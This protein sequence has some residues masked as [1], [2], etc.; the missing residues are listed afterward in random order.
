M[1]TEPEA[2]TPP[3]ELWPQKTAVVLL[4]LGTPAEPTASAVRPYLRE[5]LFDA[6]VIDLPKL[7]RWLLVNLIIAPFR[8]GTSA[9]KYRRIWTPQGSP[10]MVHS[11]ALRERLAARLADAEVLLAMR[12]GRPSIAEA[13][14]RIDALRATRVVLLPLFPQ[15]SSAAWGS[16]AQAFLRA[17][18]ELNTLPATAVVPP[19]FDHEAFLVASAA[20]LGDALASQPVEHVVFSY[21][22]LPH[23]QAKAAC[24]DGACLVDQPDT[25]CETARPE[26][27]SCYRAQCLATSRQLARRAGVTAFSTVFQSRLGRSAWLG[28][29]LD[30]ALVALARQGLKRVAVACP[31]FVADCLETLEEVG[32]GAKD[33]FLREGGQSFVLVP[34]LNAD[35][36]WVSGL[37][38]LL[39][40]W[41]SAG[42]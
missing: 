18:S 7:P 37:E 36:R 13:V 26:N 3:S 4:N 12:Y 6:R 41:L 32:L 34:A 39:R 19:F 2:P 40:P 5:F 30:D 27:R 38:R 25:C 31:A 10:L 23:R 14:A 28:P 11:V 1:R 24:R 16:A 8:S 21:H 22:G 33:V 29:S 42:R 9:A 35:P 15:Y 17:L 20:R